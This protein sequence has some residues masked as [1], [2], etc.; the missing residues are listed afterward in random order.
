MHGPD[1]VAYLSIEGK[2]GGCLEVARASRPWSGETFLVVILSG[3]MG[4]ALSF[5]AIYC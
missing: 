2:F 5:P 4:T 1:R 3:K